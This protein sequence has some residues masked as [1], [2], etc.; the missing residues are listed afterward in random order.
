MDGAGF[1]RQEKLAPALGDWLQHG[2]EELVKAPN[3]SGESGH[4]RFDPIRDGADP[5]GRL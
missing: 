2:V 4:H 1:A 5:S 3:V